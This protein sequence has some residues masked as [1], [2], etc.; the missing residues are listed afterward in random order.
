[1]ERDAPTSAGDRGTR[2]LLGMRVLGVSQVGV[3]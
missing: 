2:L 3:S 1:M